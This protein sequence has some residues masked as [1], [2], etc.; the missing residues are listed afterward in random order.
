M[1]FKLCVLWC[2][3]WWTLPAHS[4]KKT[5]GLGELKAPTVIFNTREDWFTQKMD[6]FNPS[7]KRTWQQVL[8]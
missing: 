4:M 3:V 8:M 1:K 6:H 2:C 5:I 7:D